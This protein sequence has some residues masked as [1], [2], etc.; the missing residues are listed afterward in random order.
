MEES[1]SKRVTLAGPWEDPV[2]TAPHT[3][4]YSGKEGDGRR[5]RRSWV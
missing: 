4:D 1:C 2:N 3:T 5:R